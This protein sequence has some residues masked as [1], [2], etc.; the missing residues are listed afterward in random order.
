MVPP[1]EQRWRRLPKKR[2]EH[3]TRTGGQLNRK[4]RATNS[5]RRSNYTRPRTLD[6]V[7]ECQNL[8]LG[9]TKQEKR[10]SKTIARW[11]VQRREREVALATCLSQ[12]DQSSWNKRREIYLIS[13]HI[14]RSL[15]GHTARINIQD[16]GAAFD[17]EGWNDC[18]EVQIQTMEGSDHTIAFP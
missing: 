12:S 3:S 1:W 17:Q 14:R 10:L 8:S 16:P 15:P 11:S 6:S 2:V 9:W 5:V 7:P 18:Q 4:P 13:I